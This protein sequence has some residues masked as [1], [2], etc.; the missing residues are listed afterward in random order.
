MLCNAFGML[1]Q[2]CMYEIFTK[3][4]HLVFDSVARYI[5]LVITMQCGASYIHKLSVSY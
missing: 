4:Y 1:R 5:L 3:M 2:I